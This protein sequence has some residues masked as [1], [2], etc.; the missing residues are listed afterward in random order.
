MKNVKTITTATLIAGALCTTLLA[1]CGGAKTTA[2]ADLNP[3][4]EPVVEQSSDVAT[5]SQTDDVTY[6]NALAAE[7]F[8]DLASFSAQTIDGKTFTQDDLAKADVTVINCW[9]TFCGYCVEELP[10][11]AEWAKT[12]PENVQVITVCADYEANPEAAREILDAAGFTGTTLVSGTGDFQN[13]LGSVMY[14][15][16]TVVVDNTGKGVGDVLEGATS[17]V[18]GTFGQMVQNALD[19]RG[20]AQSHA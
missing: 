5:T 8:V 15:P 3:A 18:A 12:Q 17:D 16:T 14:L 6:E 11:I 20:E 1:G 13:L 7:G 19:A 2:A 9:A 10:A 4:P